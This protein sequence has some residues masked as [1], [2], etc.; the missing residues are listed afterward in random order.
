[1]Y[2]YSSQHPNLCYKALYS[3]ISAGDILLFKII[4]F[5]LSLGQSDFDRLFI[6]SPGLPFFVILFIKNSVV[7]R[8]RTPFNKKATQII[9][10][11]SFIAG[12]GQGSLHDGGIGGGYTD[13]YLD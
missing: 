3:G 12:Y 4:L 7:R 9:N 11:H 6:L 5:S 10:L 13:T 1:M 8:C 2:E